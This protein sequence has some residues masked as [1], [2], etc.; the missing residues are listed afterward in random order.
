M[1]ASLPPVVS[2]R[3]FPQKERVTATA[4]G[5]V[6]PNS[7]R[8]FISCQ[9]LSLKGSQSSGRRGYILPLADGRQK[10]RWKQ[11]LKVPNIKAHT[12]GDTGGSSTNC[13]TLAKAG[14]LSK[15]LDLL[16]C[17]LWQSWPVGNFSESDVKFYEGELHSYLLVL[18]IAAAI[19]FFL[20]L[21]YFPS[22]PPF[23]PS[24]SSSAPRTPVLSG[25][26]LFLLFY[27]CPSFFSFRHSFLLVSALSLWQLSSFSLLNTFPHCPLFNTPWKSSYVPRTPVL[28]SFP[29]FSL[30]SLLHL[31]FCLF[32]AFIIPQVFG[33]WPPLHR[34]GH[35]SWQP[36]C[37]RGFPAPGWPWWSPTSPR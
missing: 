28:S 4:F 26:S 10:Q 7:P 37:A 1:L 16:D 14:N 22:S 36:Q 2:S 31:P 24:K 25:R 18:A 13:S 15:E 33:S 5:M 32:L 34:L 20:T 6:C 11:T 29:S 12:G 23:P 21:A 19:L 9:F 8:W 35:L 17:G 3:W 27:P 30:L